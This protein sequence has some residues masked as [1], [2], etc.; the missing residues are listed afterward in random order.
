LTEILEKISELKKK[1]NA[2]ILAHNYQPGEIQDLA[3][4][5]GDSLGLSITAS[6]TNADV[7]VFCGVLFMAETAAILSPEKIVLLPEK[8]AGCPMADMITAEQLISLKQKYPDALVV[9]YVNSTAE[10][11]AESDYC[12]TSANAV[13]VVNSLA[14]DKKIIFVPDRNLGG[15]VTQKTNRDI[16]LWPGYCPSHVVITEKDILDTRK[17]YPDAIVMTHPECT[18]SVKALS[19]QILS[20]GQMLKFAKISDAKQFIIATETG[21]I[22]SLKK[23]N[24]E[25]EFIPASPKATCPNMKKIPLE[26]I[27][28]SLED[29]DNTTTAKSQYRVTVPEDI[30]KKAKRALERMVEVIPSN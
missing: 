6:K 3:D 22:H 14:S 9:C 30:R 18:E 8:Q 11:K 19:D 13:E 7:I 23:E 5:T 17:K 4:F 24:P 2:V 26:K 29:L 15:Y 27:L 20:T 10:V 1:H 21:I 25:A 12:C 16:V 28:W